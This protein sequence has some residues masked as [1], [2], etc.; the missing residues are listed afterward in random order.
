MEECFIDCSPGI[1]G[2]MLLG[3][4]YDLGI[5]KKIIEKP[6]KD[7]GL[8]KFYNL[9]FHE[10]K[11]SSI[12]GIKAKVE[13]VKN[14]I[15]RDW[16]SIQEL[17]IKGSLQIDLE[18][19]IISVFKLLAEAEAKV[20]GINCEEVH[21][22]EIGSVDSLVD[23]I[24]VCAGFNYLK[25]KVIY[26]NTPILGK[27]F[28]KTEH[29]LISIPSPAVVELATKSKL[30]IGTNSNSIDGELST[31]TGIALLLN[32]VDCFEPPSEYQIISYG[33]GVGNRKL[34]FP[35]LT[36]ILNISSK[37]KRYIANFNNSNS[38]RLE[39]ICIQEAWI[40]DQSSEEIASFIKILREA[41]ALDVSHS[42]I[43][44]KKG[45]M[46]FS[47]TVILPI[48]K[49][50]YFRDLWFNQTNTIGIRERRQ[51]RWTLLR[52]EGVCMTS[53]GKLKFKQV[54]K[55]NGELK[56]KPEND[57]IFILQ[58]KY[59]KSPDEIKQIIN[60]SM[61]EFIPLEEEWK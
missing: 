58:K 49:E 18:K 55:S 61:G 43:N 28:A 38:P 29:G 35:N 41:G 26:T 20:H 47:V 30:N 10:A 8:E 42:L 17:I 3:S 6:L 15:R 34:S 56:L 19:K 51:K 1:S 21:F 48:E 59:K 31:P 13:I 27:G 14:P 39:E 37:N 7:I 25:P 40:D 11:S 5:P 60:E 44:M 54:I 57:E 53:F 50:K 33:V 32:L 52:R 12:R 23:I 22:H 46:G 2:D 4:L 36:R 24:G 9:S 45:R 16:R